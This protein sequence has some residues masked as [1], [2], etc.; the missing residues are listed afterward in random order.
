MSNLTDRYMCMQ[1]M[2]GGAQALG[3]D[4]RNTLTL[5]R[6]D[7]TASSKMILRDKSNP[8]AIKKRLILVPHDIRARS[9]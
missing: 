2:V 8:C 3:M 7:S 4:M 1:L 9:V 6:N 5:S